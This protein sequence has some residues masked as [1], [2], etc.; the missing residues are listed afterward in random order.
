MIHEQQTISLSS[1]VSPHHFTM[2]GIENG[3]F[4]PVSDGRITNL[5]Q[6]SPKISPPLFPLFRALQRRSQNSPELAN[7]LRRITSI[8]FKGYDFTELPFELNVESVFPNLQMCTFL[9]CPNLS[10]LKVAT[11]LITLELLSCENCPSITSLS[12]LSEL[13]QES[14]LKSLILY[15]CGLNPTH[16]DDWSESFRAI[17]K[18]AKYDGF[19]L[20]IDYDSQMTCLPGSVK[21]LQTIKGSVR[22]RLQHNPKLQRLPHDIGWLQNMLRLDLSNNKLLTS[23]PWTL[24]R[25]SL[26]CQVTEPSG[27]KQTVENMEAQFKVPRQRFIT[28][29]AKFSIFASRKV[30]ELT[31]VLYR[32]GGKGHL[33]VR[34]VFEVIANDF[35]QIEHH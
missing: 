17:G 8:E 13:P 31:E 19:G 27:M 7:R 25:L 33:R 15:K 35:E 12:S 1:L 5:L 22:M 10:S 24:G 34:E 16:E 4:G 6:L 21:L 28:G 14:N 2:A 20:C 3:M 9:N 26:D 32:P 11:D 30:A 23:V 29:I 18:A